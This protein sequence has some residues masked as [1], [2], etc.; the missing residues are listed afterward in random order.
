MFIPLHDTNPLLHVKRPYVNWALIAITIIIFVV[1]QAQAGLL[2]GVGLPASFG[3]IPS[4]L[5]ETRALPPD[6]VVIPA[7]WT[8]VS[9]AFF[10]GGWM[11]LIGNMLFLWVFGDNIEDA[12]G[13]IKYLLFY[14]L[15]AAGGG[16]AHAIFNANSEA[17]L[18]GASGAV[19]G[20]VAAYLILHPKVKVWILALGRIPLRLSALWVLGAWILMQIY[21]LFAAADSEVAWWA[22]IGGLICGAALVLL[23]KR[24][25]VPLFDRE[26]DTP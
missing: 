22:H 7:D 10:H 14:L 19:A 3:V 21:N 5:F 2:G 18:I 25:E 6:L 20:V 8:L 12:L 1:F 16:Y 17:P 24:R 15:C 9:Y 11:H 26:L 4:V 13:H 23:L